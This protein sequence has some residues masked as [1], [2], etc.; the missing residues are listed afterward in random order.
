[1]ARKHEP[2]KPSSKAAPKPAGDDDLEVLHP[3][4][5][6]S[7]AGRDLLMREYGFVEGLKL[8]PLYAPLIE[9]LKPVLAEGELP[10]LEQILDLL[11]DHAER[12]PQLMASACDQPLEW[13]VSLGHEQGHNLMLVWW[14]V[15]GPFFVRS[16]AG[17]L[18]SKKVQEMR[19]AGATST[20]V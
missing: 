18:L 10:D 4:R 19:R 17:Q 6:C 7:I 15:N 2:T 1:M 8:R 3:E 13:V 14:G 11:V 16:A 12:L 20:S 5:Q 9:T